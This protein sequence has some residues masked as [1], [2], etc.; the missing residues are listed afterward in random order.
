MATESKPKI[1]TKE[2]PH[3]VALFEAWRGLKALGWQE[4]R[5]FK[6]PKE[7]EQFE[8]IELGSTGIHRAVVRG[9]DPEKTCWVDHE[10]PAHPFLVRQ[11]TKTEA[12]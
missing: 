11:I 9:M 8:M 2:F 12:K 6:F 10:W 5:Y 3:L 1:T 4:P 7:G